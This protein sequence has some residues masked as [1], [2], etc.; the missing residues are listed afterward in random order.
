[1]FLDLVFL[2]C[3]YFPLHLYVIILLWDLL[4]WVVPVKGDGQVSSGTVGAG[5]LTGI[6]L[7]RFFLVGM[8]VMG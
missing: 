8:G 7:I 4:V 1:M 3:I 5:R 6:I 2:D